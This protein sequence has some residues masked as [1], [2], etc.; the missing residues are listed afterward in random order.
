MEVN[1]LDSV[2]K[3]NRLAKQALG[4]TL[5][6]RARVICERTEEF[7]VAHEPVDSSEMVLLLPVVGFIIR[8]NRRYLL[9]E[10]FSRETVERGYIRILLDPFENVY[11]TVSNINKRTSCLGK[12]SEFF[13]GSGCCESLSRTLPD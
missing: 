7:G 2:Q 13:G 9:A 12:K 10:V 6:N 11:S 4:N 5:A 3:S 8:S 1:L